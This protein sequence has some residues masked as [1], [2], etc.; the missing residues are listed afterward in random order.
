MSQGKRKMKNWTK[1]KFF[2]L[3]FFGVKDKITTFFP[4]K[5]VTLTK[6]RNKLVYSWGLILREFFE[7]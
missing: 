7:K 6:K 3:L 4:E 5:Q 1:P 2:F